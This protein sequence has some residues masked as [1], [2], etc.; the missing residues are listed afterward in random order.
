MT[1]ATPITSL[2]LAI[3]VQ[4][5][6]HPGDY[7]GALGFVVSSVSMGCAAAVSCTVID[8]AVEINFGK[9]VPILPSSHEFELKSLRRH[10]EINCEH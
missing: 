6:D 10:P 4:S 9:Y 5:C 1:L 8:I 2:D 7:W 3:H